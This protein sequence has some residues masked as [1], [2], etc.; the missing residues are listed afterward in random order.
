MHMFCIRL[1]SVVGLNRAQIQVPIRR[2]AEQR[3]Q[4]T[5]SPVLQN[6]TGMSVNGLLHRTGSSQVS[7]ITYL[8]LTNPGRMEGK[9][10]HAFSP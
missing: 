4:R 2:H 8:A 3:S 5:Q 1:L 9:D 6:L 7:A 10:D